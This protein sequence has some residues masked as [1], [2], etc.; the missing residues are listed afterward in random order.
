M[1]PA[2]TVLLIEDDRLLRELV[3]EVL[4]TSGCRVETAADGAEGLRRARAR[5]P[6]LILMDLALPGIDGLETTRRLRSDP[7]T[8]E[9]PVV[10]LTAHAMAGDRE[11]ALAAGFDDYFSKPIDFTGLVS[12]IGEILEEHGG[13]EGSS[14]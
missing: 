11:R 2:P 8:R 6:D 1:I 5:T 13:D 14:P 7:R 3:A 4:G 10:A 9:I 12:A